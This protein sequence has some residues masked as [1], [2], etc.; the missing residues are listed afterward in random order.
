MT[1]A[2]NTTT[3]LREW[4]SHHLTARNH[5]RADVIEMT[6]QSG[7][8]DYHLRTKTGEQSYLIM[9]VIDV[10]AIKT[11]VSA[12]QHAVIITTNSTQSLQATING[13]EDLI[14]FT[15]LAIFFV[16]PHASY[17]KHWVLRP[18][19]HES[20]IGR[21]NLASALQTLFSNIAVYQSP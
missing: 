11:K 7:G 15:K 19:A 20:L 21:K 13:W 5:I 3:E 10:P 17:E 9:P 2:S 6:P 4:L 1:N 14:T 8:W 16:N 18:S 12:E